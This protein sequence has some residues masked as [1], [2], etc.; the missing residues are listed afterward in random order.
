MNMPVGALGQV[1]DHC[2]DG[3]ANVSFF[4]YRGGH[5]FHFPEDSLEIVP[6]EKG[7]SESRAIE[8]RRVDAS[9]RPFI[10][11]ALTTA[12]EDAAA[13]KARVSKL[14]AELNSLTDV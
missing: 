2:N 7:D 3:R 12:K 14:Q 9:R 4:G 1:R 8:Q 6:K 5:T 13:A 10:K 11:H